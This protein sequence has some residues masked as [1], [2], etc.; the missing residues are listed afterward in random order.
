MNT[1]LDCIAN[2]LYA[3]VEFLILKGSLLFFF[4]DAALL[5]TP[6]ALP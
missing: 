5:P 1:F 3:C 6:S 4:P 2:I